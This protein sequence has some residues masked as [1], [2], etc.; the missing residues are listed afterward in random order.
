MFLQNEDDSIKVNGKIVAVGKSRDN[1]VGKRRD[2]NKRVRIKIPK[3]EYFLSVID[4]KA[5]EKNYC[6]GFRDSIL[7]E[8]EDRLVTK[9]KN[10]KTMEFFS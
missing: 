8:L 3:L 4:M 10:V 5:M 9:V 6:E 2:R 7:A 1:R